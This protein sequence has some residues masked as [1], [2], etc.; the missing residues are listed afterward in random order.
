[1]RPLRFLLLAALTLPVAARGDDWPQW[2]GPQ[3][4]NVWRETGLIDK[5]PEG[6]PP[7]LWR[8]PVAGGYAGPAVAG[9]RVF[10]TDYVTKDNVKVSNFERQSFSG[11]ERV[12][13]LEEATG[14]PLWKH[15]YPVKYTI[16]YPAGPRCTPVVDGELVYTLGAEGHL[17]CFQVADGKIVWQHH[18][19]EKYNTKAALWGYAAHP[20]IDG[21]RLL[22]LAGGEGTHIVAFHKRTG[23]EIWSALT[24]TEQGYSPPTIFQVGDRR[25]LVLLRPDAVTAVAPETGKEL[26]STEYQASNGSIIMSPLKYKDYLYVAGYSDKSLLLKVDSQQPKVEVVWRDKKTDAFSPVNVQPFLQ[27]DVAYGFDQGGVLVALKLPE[28][29]RLWETSEPIGARKVGSAT[30]FIIKQGER[31]WLFNEKGEIVLA[32]L[33]PQGYEEID[34]AQVIEPTNLAFGRPVVW[35]QPALANRHVYMRNDK[36]LICVDV[37]AK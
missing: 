36:E 5:F 15:E 10:I 29:K 1:M 34:R 17:I 26:W 20:L 32:K 28:G 16:S 18:L 31:F 3:R 8:A 23:D 11:I 22:C 12:L 2:M 33:S 14:K 6:G 30:A 37:A 25:E 35:S 4:D 24:S 7:V 19:T 13:C 27:D 21:D 9:G